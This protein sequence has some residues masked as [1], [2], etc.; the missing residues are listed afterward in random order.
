MV[1]IQ[2]LTVV[3]Q[4]AVFIVYTSSDSVS[5]NGLLDGAAIIDSITGGNGDIRI[6][7]MQMQVIK[8]Q[9]RQ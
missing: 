1:V 6:Y 3:F 5:C 7:G 4:P 2:L 9:I 8:Q